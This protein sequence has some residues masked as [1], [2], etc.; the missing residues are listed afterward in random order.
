MYPLVVVLAALYSN[1][2]I[3]LTSVS[4]EKVH[5]D[6]AFV[7]VKPTVVI[8]SPTTIK[9]ACKTFNEQPRGIMQKYAQWR[10]ASSLAEGVMPKITGHLSRPRLIYT[11]EDSA[12]TAAPLTLAVLGDMRLNTG[13]RTVYA[14]TD[15]K[16][17]GAITQTSIYDYRRGEQA[18]HANFGGPVSS[19][20]IKLV[21]EN[22]NK[23]SDDKSLGKLV[24]TGPAVAG[25]ET[26]VDRFMTM[27]DSHTLAYE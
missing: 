19:V 23:N 8:A 13:A 6:T 11:F 7:K 5:F 25:G 24:V 22:G 21:D 18:E 4:G 17:A 1:S 2:S 14:F 9:Q 12:S 10:N 15:A 16:V 20:E 26:K 27:T 3:A